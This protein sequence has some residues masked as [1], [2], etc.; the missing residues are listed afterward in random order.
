MTVDYVREEK[1]MRIDP[2]DKRERLLEKLS[3]LALAHAIVGNDERSERIRSALERRYRR[4]YKP[5]D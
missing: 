3:Y 4:P 1:E 5:S 2:R